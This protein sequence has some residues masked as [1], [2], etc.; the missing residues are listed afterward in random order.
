MKF[1]R[2]LAT[3]HRAQRLRSEFFTLAVREELGAIAAETAKHTPRPPA[4]A[5]VLE[6]GAGQDPD[7]STAL[8]IDKYVADDFE[9]PGERPMSFAKPVVVADGEQ[10][11][12]RDG[13]FDYAIASH[14]LEHAQHPAEFAGELSRVASA[15]FVQ[16]PSRA[17][18]LTFGWAYHPWLIDR[19]A[20]GLVF[21]PRG[22]A[23]APIGEVFHQGY[24]DS[25]FFRAWW[26]ANRSVWHHSM[27]WQGE[28]EVSVEGA[29]EAAQTAG[30]DLERTVA[31]LRRA[32][33]D[34]V[35]TPLPEHVSALLVCPACRSGFAS[36]V[37]GATLGCTGCGASYIVAGDVPVLVVGD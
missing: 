23:V 13:A 34:G 2:S 21:H 9:R 5:V 11:P 37:R 29:S 25:A 7:P 32:K 27:E 24:T 36:P 30:F 1:G 3:L 28:L 15:G 17:A 26:A 22:K 19:S 4:G 33:T 8:V 35:T 14:V 6:V 12:L 31:R 16:V 20:G 10:L 18:E